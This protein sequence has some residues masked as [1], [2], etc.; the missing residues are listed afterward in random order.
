ML[1]KNQ[2]VTIERP[3]RTLGV[4]VATVPAVIAAGFAFALIAKATTWPV[5]LTQFT[6]IS[7]ALVL[8]V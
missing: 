6:A 2:G 4:V 7:G 8:I 3:R 1:L 5:S